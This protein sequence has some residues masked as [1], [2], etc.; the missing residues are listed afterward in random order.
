MVDVLTGGRVIFSIAWGLRSGGFAAEFLGRH[1]VVGI[2]AA[3]LLA[4]GVVT[5][6]TQS[7]LRENK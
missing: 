6:F 3:L 2:L 5:M 4:T 1:R 7:R